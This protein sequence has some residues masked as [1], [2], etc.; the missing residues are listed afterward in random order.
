MSVS[1]ARSS[2]RRFKIHDFDKFVCL[3]TGFLNEFLVGCGTNCTQQKRKHVYNL[4]S[5]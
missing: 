4:L 3:S 1:L 2:F 5:L